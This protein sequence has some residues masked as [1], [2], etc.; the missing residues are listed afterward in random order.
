MQ[1]AIEKA[2]QAALRQT[3]INDGI[4]FV[5]AGLAAIGVI[6]VPS[7]EVQLSHSG[8]AEKIT[9][10]LTVRR[11][12]FAAAP[13]ARSAAG[14]SVFAL[15]SADLRAA[16][17]SGAVPPRLVAGTPVRTYFVT[18]INLDDPLAY[19]FTLMDRN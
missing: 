11:A 4:A 6:G 1:S 16:V 10:M 15:R 8:P 18:G 14:L 19:E 9:A 13:E 2:Q 12:W 3:E 17:R 7:L 5:Y